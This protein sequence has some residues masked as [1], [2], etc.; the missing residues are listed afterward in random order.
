MIPRSALTCGPLGP[1]P[2]GGWLDIP[3]VPAAAGSLDRERANI[4]LEA[5]LPP[6]VRRSAGPAWEW[7]GTG[8]GRHKVRARAA[9]AGGFKSACAPDGLYPPLNFRGGFR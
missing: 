5:T 8:G 6:G 2:A 7:A 4:I 3:R 9:E 1:S